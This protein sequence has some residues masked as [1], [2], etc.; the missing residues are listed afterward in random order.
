MLSGFLETIFSTIILD[1]AQTYRRMAKANSFEELNCWRAGRELVTLVYSLTAT[2]P[3]ARDFAM[4]DQV[5][6]AALSVMNNIAEGF[7]RRTSKEF[8]RFL[9]ISHASCIEVKSMTYVFEDLKYL[10]TENIQAIRA[11]VD[12]TKGLTR[13]LMKYLRNLDP[14]L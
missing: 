2:G 14:K 5:R 7:G 3:I 6:R 8:L 12:E 1:C 4:K 13:G 10:S 9:D 11:K